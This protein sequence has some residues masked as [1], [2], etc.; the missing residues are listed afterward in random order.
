VTTKTTIHC[1]GYPAWA[2]TAVA[3]L[4]AGWVKLMSPP[5]DVDRFPTLHKDVRV[6]TDEWDRECIARGAEGAD[7]YMARMAPLWAPY[8][9]WANVAFELPNEPPCNGNEELA[10]LD[11]FTMRCITLANYTRLRLIVLNLAEGNPHDNGTGDAGVTA[12]KVQ[13]LA[14]AVR[15]AVAGGHLVGLH[16]YGRPGVED[17]TGRYHALRCIDM[18]DWWDEAGVDVSSLRVAL[19]E[20]GVDGGIAGN[21]PVHGWRD[22]LSQDDYVAQVVEGERALRRIPQMAFAALFT[23]APQSPWGSYEQDEVT[24]AKV[25]EGIA[26]LPAGDETEVAT[27]RLWH[28]ATGEVTVVPVEE[29]LRGVVPAEM[30]VTWGEEA[31]KAQAVAA[32]TYTLAAIAKPR[33]AAKG[34]DLCTETDCEAWSTKTHARAD[35]AVSATA[36]ETWGADGSYVALCGRDDC[37]HCQGKAGTNGAHF[38]GRLCQYGARDMAASGKDYHEILRLYYGESEDDVPEAGGGGTVSE[39]Y[40]EI[41]AYRND[42]SP[43][44]VAA[45]LTTYS[46]V[47]KRAVVAAGQKV[48]RLTAIRERWGDAAQV[49]VAVGADRKPASGVRFAWYWEGGSIADE[50]PQSIPGQWHTNYQLL[51]PTGADG[52][53]APG[54]GMGAYHAAGKP[55]PHAMWV[56]DP[57]APSDIVGGLGMLTQTNHY[58]VNLEWTL[59]TQGEDDDGEDDVVFTGLFTTAEI[60]TIKAHAGDVPFMARAC[61][62][63]G[64]MPTNVEWERGYYTYTWGIEPGTGALVTVRAKT[65]DWTEAAL[66]RVRTYR[67]SP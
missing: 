28:R 11:A 9:G 40:P 49:G 57:S 36:G 46:F 65:G 47:Y 62:A 29:Y 52:Q 61:G 63:K 21:P 25:A 58:H 30:F 33:H 4:G 66:A 19:T 27:V 60:A 50:P 39:A 38:P 5:T 15:A 48:W 59:V 12:W 22:L 56:A 3:N 20:W 51:N 44:S 54:M 13:Q 17:L 31:L 8:R 23:A 37:P 32:R 16:G 67:Y 7:A 34:A 35:A 1:Q 53:T 64:L 26:A 42:G 43:T 2:P 14:G 18:I 41:K 24:V 55:G 6:W 10:N 45:L